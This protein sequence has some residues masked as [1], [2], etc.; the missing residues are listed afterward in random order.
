MRSPPIRRPISTLI[1]TVLTL[2]ALAAPLDPGGAAP[3]NPMP[4]VTAEPATGGAKPPAT[5]SRRDSRVELLLRVQGPQAGASQAQAV[6]PAARERAADAGRTDLPPSAA[7]P[8]VLQELKE[9][10]TSLFGESAARPGDDGPGR[11]IESDPAGVERTAGAA[12][13]IT[14][15]G[16]AP[17]H[18]AGS[19]AGTEGLLANPVVRFIRANRV[20]SI[21]ASIGVLA[22]VWLLTSYRSR[23][24]RPRR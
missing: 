2:P 14:P 3:S 18:G 15:A 23:S 12:A 21:G 9:L 17:A 19:G 16:A 11:R 8:G 1:A 7:S 4:E 24:R 13:G 20:S 6:P 5:D 22:A 10:R